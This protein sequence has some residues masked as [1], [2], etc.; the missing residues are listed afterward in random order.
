MSTERRIA[1]ASV[2]ISYYYISEYLYAKDT[3]NVRSILGTSVFLLQLHPRSKAHSFYPTSR[4]K[5]RC[6]PNCCLVRN[7]RTRLH[8]EKKK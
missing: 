2:L 8:V 6:P 3:W 1:N 7:R 4:C 5:L